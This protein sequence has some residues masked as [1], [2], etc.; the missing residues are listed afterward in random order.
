[1]EPA[2]RMHQYF[3]R[4]ADAVPGAL[5]LVCDGT[6]L[7]YRELE[8]R[9][10]RLA[11]W[12]IEHGAGPGVTVGLLLERS[13]SSY[14]ALLAVLKT[15]AAFVPIDPSYPAD[16]VAFIAGDAGLRVVL[17]TSNLAA[18]HAG[19]GDRLFALD[20]NEPKLARYSAARPVV[21]DS[22]DALAYVIYTSGTTGRPKGVAVNHSSICFF[23][24][25]CTPIYGVTA[26]D[27]VY[28]GMTL[29]FDF[30]IEEVWPTWLAGAAVIA[31][32]TDSRRIGSG[33]A[34]FL[35]ENRVS[36]LCC[37][38][39]LLATLDRDL[40][41]IHTLIVGGEACPR[42]MVERWSGPGRRLLN[43]SAPTETTVTASWTELEA[44]KPVTIGR[45]MPGYRMYVLD[46][47]LRPLP[48][49]EPGEICIGGN[50]VAVGYLNRPDLTET[51]FVADPFER[52]RRM[53]RSGDLGCFAPNGEIEF[54]GRIDTQVKIRG[55]RIELGEIEAVLVED[56]VVENAIVSTTAAGVQPEELVAYLKLRPGTTDSE[57]LRERLAV[58]LRRRLPVYMVPA[59]IEILDAIPMLASGKAD[60]KQLP[61]PRTPRLA[62]RT[63]EFIAPATP[64]EE[65]IAAVWSSVFGLADISVEADFFLELGGHSLFAAQ[66]MSK[67]RQQER[68]RGLGIADLYS[69]PTIRG[70]GQLVEATPGQNPASAAGRERHILSHS[71][72][73]VWFTGALQFVL[74]YGLFAILMAPVAALVVHHARA[75]LA[76]DRWDALVPF[77]LI[78]LSVLLPVVLKWTLIGRFRAGTYPL[79]GFYYCRWW[80]VRKALDLSPLHLLAGS[81]L[82]AVY[83]RLLGARI[84][85][86]CQIATAQLHLPDLIEIG[87]RASL[88]YEVELQP[89]LVEDGYLHMAP[90]RVGA[91]A[92]IG[93][94]SVLLLG[95][96]LG[97]RARIAEQSLVTGF[98]KVPEGESWA[99]SPSSRAVATDPLLDRMERTAAVPRRPSVGLWLGYLAA[100][101]TLEALPVV[102]ALPGVLLL[103]WADGIGGIPLS[104][105]LTPVAGLL[106]ILTTC[107]LIGLGKRLVLPRVRPGIYPEL[108]GFGLRK[109]FADRLMLLSLTLT[110]TLYATLYTSPWLRMLGARIGAWSE[111]STVSHIDPDMLTLGEQTFVA[112][113]ASIGSATFHNGSIALAPSSVGDRTFIGNAAVIRSSVKLPG[114]S[115]IGVASVVP[116]E[117]M[118]AGSS[119]LGSPSIFLPKRQ[120]WG[121]FSESVTYRPKAS[122]VAYRLFIE[123][124]RV[125]LPAALL[126]LLGILVAVAA[127]RLAGSFDPGELV[128]L[129]P[130]AYFAA[131]LGVTF[132]VAAVKW[133]LIG[134]YRPRI[135][136]LWAPFVRH[137]ELVTGLYESA[138]VAM[139]GQL[140]AGT[141]FVAPLL[142]LF[143]ARIGRRVYLETTFLTEFDLVHVGDDC[144][145]GRAA[146]LQT[147]LF[148]DRV[149]KMSRVEIGNGCVVG[150]RAVVLYD[151]TLEDGARLD[152]LSLV[153]KGETLPAHTRWRGVPARM[154]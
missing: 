79:W 142:G 54:L 96:E 56:A 55:F 127:V 103:A 66:V 53:Y 143:G 40:P 25:V 16:R 67:L 93:T 35:A 69:H 44:G 99:G 61:A 72:A 20:Q 81:P 128:M 77:A 100:A 4:S 28:Q 145:I 83:A 130:A 95:S 8:A 10:N 84:G 31:G 104:L 65:T 6:T 109:W 60:R 105:A 21:S 149:M 121:D 98:Q 106:F 154:V 148:E 38:P 51:R 24:S 33:L 47:K 45:P 112:D 1:I 32:P 123:F 29:A 90:I 23:L 57:T 70:L 36:I 30:S 139:L 102:M 34:D 117:P 78:A 42:D 50:G 39:T 129:L 144:S 76:L 125:I 108:S 64:F 86:G 80:L 140:L 89:F 37:V 87:D 58:E 110:N 18:T 13:V 152:A 136:P 151:S 132:L 19:L 7:S 146:S 122:L 97:A 111:V 116:T 48:T 120:V 92:H 71:S 85:E 138:V 17:T 82:M 94:K 52:G 46:D 91:G 59:Y 3:E 12:L 126:Y 62:V 88:G 41:S 11:H 137:S 124:F 68:F 119:W 73:R 134:K 26:E 153:M 9:A 43:A 115:L 150:P 27:R 15:G 118:Q 22:G 113:L 63:G 147:H 5:A 107:L 49:G 75:G 14:V 2:R 133:V 135:E 74:L 114:N 101:F 141:P 131:A